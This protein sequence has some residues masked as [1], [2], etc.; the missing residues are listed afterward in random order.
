MGKTR[1]LFRAAFTNK[2]PCFVLMSSPEL[3]SE[4]HPATAKGHLGVVGAGYL[5]MLCNSET[6]P[7]RLSFI[8]LNGMAGKD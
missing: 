2:H 5:T 7:N 1:R 6:F 3:F 4:T 8:R